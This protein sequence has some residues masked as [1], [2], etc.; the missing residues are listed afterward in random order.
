MLPT[1]IRPNQILIGMNDGAAAPVTHMRGWRHQLSQV[2][3]SIVWRASTDELGHVAAPAKEQSHFHSCGMVRA[4]A[5]VSWHLLLWRN[6]QLLG[7]PLRT[8]QVSS[9]HGRKQSHVKV[10]LGRICDLACG[11]VLLVTLGRCFA[12][13][14]TSTHMY[15]EYSQGYA[16]LLLVGMS[17]SGRPAGRLI[18]RGTS[19]QHRIQAGSLPSTCA[20]ERQRDE[21]I[22]VPAK[23]LDLATFAKTRLESSRSVAARLR[24]QE[25]AVSVE[26]L[27]KRCGAS[28]RYAYGQRW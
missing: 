9:H 21:F 12:R 26:L 10:M 18:C 11:T 27:A 8:L 7:R 25:D 23:M 28:K 6:S 13:L 14:D 16:L 15:R 20:V 5:D 22:T 2:S 1:L 19:T 24:E 3:D 17:C 4:L